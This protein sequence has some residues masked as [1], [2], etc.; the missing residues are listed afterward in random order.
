MLHKRSW[1]PF[2][3]FFLTLV[4]IA[5]VV[6]SFT[7]KGQ[8]EKRGQGAPPITMISDITYQRELSG[9]VKTFLNAYATA[10]D[11]ASRSALVQTML[12]QLLH[13]R[14]PAQEKDLHLELAL[15]LQQMKE[16][17]ANHSQDASEGF[18]RLNDAVSQT[19]WLHL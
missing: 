7:G 12:N 8:L 1:F 11:D 9:N 13:M 6:S 4:L 14:V 16:G 15:S 10:T 3:V 19:S 17:L 18:A 5:L 2:V